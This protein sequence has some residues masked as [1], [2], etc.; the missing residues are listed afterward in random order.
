MHQQLHLAEVLAILA[1][2]NL[3]GLNLACSRNQTKNQAEQ[4]VSQD[5]GDPA[6]GRG[7]KWTCPLIVPR[8]AIF[9]ITHP[10]IG[11]SR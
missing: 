1:P 7:K 9:S 3:G 2:Q 8:F 5:N 11:L 6:K 4:T 10:V